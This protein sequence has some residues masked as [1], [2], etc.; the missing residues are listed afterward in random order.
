MKKILIIFLFG[1]TLIQAQTDYRVWGSLGQ[2]LDRFYFRYGYILNRLRIGMN[3]DTTLIG[4]DVISLG[5][6]SLHQ[7]VRAKYDS[8]FGKSASRM[9]FVDTCFIPI[10]KIGDGWWN[11]NQLRLGSRDTLDAHIIAKSIQTTAKDTSLVIAWKDTNNVATNRPM[12]IL[13]ADT[14]NGV[15]QANTKVTGIKFAGTAWGFGAS[16]E[17]YYIYM[18]G[19]DYW[20]SWGALKASDLSSGAAI[21]AGTSITAGTTVS[22]TGYIATIRTFAV[23]GTSD[24]VN[25][26]GKSVMAVNTAGGSITIGGFI[27]GVS[28]QILHLYNSGANNVVLED[29]EA[30]GNQ[31]IKTPGGI[32]ITITAEGG[33]TLLC[34]GSLWWIIGIA[35]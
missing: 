22:G 30:T 3:G 34:D 24:T 35:Q 25:I 13:R 33:A 28:G 15:T 1:F 31:D 32:D 27:G 7:A 9:Y 26:M 12:L 17:D 29:D 8:L 5:D 18:G 20:G 11:A 23:A 16:G 2:P 19:N 21:T 10:M 4:R 6:W 14:A